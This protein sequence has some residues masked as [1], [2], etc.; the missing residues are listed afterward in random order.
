MNLGEALLELKGMRSELVRLMEVRENSFSYEGEKPNE[1][2]KDLSKEIVKL[3]LEIRKLKIKIENT[4]H[5]SFIDT[6]DGKMTI[7]ETIIY[8]AD[9]RSELASLEKLRGKYRNEDSWRETKPK[10]YQVEQ[11]ELLQLIR[12]VEKKKVKM[13]GF[14]SSWNWKVELK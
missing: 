3:T 11:K 10:K 13:D 1:D 5:T 8:I 9:M 14:L 4:N 2:I 6:P 12:S 7:A